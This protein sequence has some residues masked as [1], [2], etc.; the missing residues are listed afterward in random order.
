MKL[1]HYWTLLP[2]RQSLLTQ[3]EV[4]ST[5]STVTV[6]VMPMHPSHVIFLLLLLQINLLT[7]LYLLIF[8]SVGFWV[9]TSFLQKLVRILLSNNIYTTFD[10]S[11]VVALLILPCRSTVTPPTQYTPVFTRWRSQLWCLKSRLIVKTQFHFHL[12]LQL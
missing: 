10:H 12:S 4:L 2:S 9:F 7:S 8:L 11:F 5:F 1:Q 6:L 3:F